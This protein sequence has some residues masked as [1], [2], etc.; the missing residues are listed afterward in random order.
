[1]NIPRLLARLR[2]DE[3]LR[4]QEYRDAKGNRTIGYGHNLNAAPLPPWAVRA[5]ARTRTGEDGIVITA[6]VAEG[7][8]LADTLQAVADA[9]AI[10]PA[11]GTFTDARQE[12]LACM[13][14]HLG[15]RGLSRFVRMRDAIDRGDW[16]VAGAE[17][18]DSSR[19]R[20]HFSRAEREALA[21][22]NGNWPA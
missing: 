6:E 3:G 13:A 8:L 9:I 18:M 16:Q 20:N 4:L 12:A 5:A 17:A 19:A 11:F 7:V 22:Q 21:L 2:A 10:F 14:F 15:R 1:M